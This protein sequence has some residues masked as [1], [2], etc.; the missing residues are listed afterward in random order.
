MFYWSVLAYALLKCSLSGQVEFS[1]V[2]G[3][4]GTLKAYF[5]F[6][7]WQ[8]KGTKFGKNT[9]LHYE[10]AEILPRISYWFILT[11]QKILTLQERADSR[12]YFNSS[13]WQHQ[14]FWTKIESAVFLTGRWSCASV[15]L[16]RSLTLRVSW[17]RKETPRSDVQLSAPMIERIMRSLFSSR[18]MLNDAVLRATPPVSFPVSRSLFQLSENNL[19]G[20]GTKQGN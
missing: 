12:S 18:L 13:F 2:R 10:I 5:W 16:Y 8:V 1:F 6:W 3:N 15:S 19:Q 9:L 14:S 17:Q 11:R 7:A 4:A 20:S